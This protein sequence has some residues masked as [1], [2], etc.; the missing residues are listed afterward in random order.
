METTPTPT[1]TPISQHLMTATSVVESYNA[2]QGTFAPTRESILEATPTSTPISQ[3][4]MTA[5]S[6][7]ET[8]EASR[9]T[10]EP[11]RGNGLNATPT[12]TSKPVSPPQ[13][14]ATSIIVTFAA[15]QG[16]FV[17]TQDTIVATTPTPTPVNQQDQDSTISRTVIDV[18]ELPLCLLNM[19]LASSNAISGFVVHDVQRSDTLSTIATQYGIAVRDLRSA[20]CLTADQFEADDM[21]VQQLYIPLRE[22]VV[23]V[24]RNPIQAGSIVT[25]NNLRMYYTTGPIIEGA[26]TDIENIV[27]RQTFLDVPQGKIVV[28]GDLVAESTRSTQDLPPDTMVITIPIATTAEE[29]NRAGIDDLYGRINVWAA[30]ID[31][32]S[33]GCAIA[34][35]EV[36]SDECP[37]DDTT[38]Y[39]AATGILLNTVALS[40]TD[41]T[42]VTISVPPERASWIVGLIEAGVPLDIRSVYLS[43]PRF[44]TPEP[45][46]TGL[47]NIPL[48][49]P[50]ETIDN[51]GD[52]P[53]GM[54]ISVLAD[55]Y[56][57]D[58]ECRQMPGNADDCISVEQDQPLAEGTISNVI[59]VA[60][61]SESL[62]DVSVVTLTLS[63]DN[64]ITLV[65]MAES[66]FGF[67]YKLEPA[68]E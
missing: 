37:H 19:L 64:A 25:S 24:A 15:S 39:K 8:F 32:T 30:L 21:K 11:L 55:I 67:N 57:V 1:S 22:Q 12:P 38:W 48:M 56:V 42:A 4:L 28:E 10:V 31:G 54:A 62:S 20:N 60:E 26:I 18:D 29:S 9:Q 68:E 33:E 36:P 47:T 34:S 16:T 44:P 41:S 13:L 27:G 53:I 45:D 51:L 6:V 2:S 40:G 7:I 43:P 46:E 61:N 50:Q 59:A 3:H 65:S 58:M 23:Y 17:P 49:L 66:G 63:P 14:T 52:T 5:T 35:S